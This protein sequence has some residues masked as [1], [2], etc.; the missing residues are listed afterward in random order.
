MGKR[1][2]TLV[3][4]TVVIAILAILAGI[5]VP[6]MAGY[7]DKAADGVNEVNLLTTQRQ[8]RIRCGRRKRPFPSVPGRFPRPRLWVC[9]GESTR[10]KPVR[11]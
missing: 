5:A 8:L 2:F 4:L 7:R 10:W 1:G 11:T 3:E 6:A 9:G